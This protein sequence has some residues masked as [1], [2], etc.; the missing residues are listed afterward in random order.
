M[1][2]VKITVT[3]TQSISIFCVEV[4]GATVLSTVAWT[5]LVCPIITWATIYRRDAAVDIAWVR[6]ASAA[7]DCRIT[8]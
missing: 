7:G 8:A 1:T 5:I 3:E 2:A 4:L 6:V